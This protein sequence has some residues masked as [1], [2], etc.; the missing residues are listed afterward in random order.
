M[1]NLNILRVNNVVISSSLRL[2]LSSH[3]ARGKRT[4]SVTEIILVGGNVGCIV[5]IGYSSQRRRI[6]SS[7]MV[8]DNS[9][10][11]RIGMR[12]DWSNLS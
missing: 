7:R 2:G 1:I 6:R 3:L 9:I 11:P 12:N 4:T 10:S 5:S 8:D